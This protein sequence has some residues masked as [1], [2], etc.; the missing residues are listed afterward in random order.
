MNSAGGGAEKSKKRVT[1]FFW[2][3]PLQHQHFGRRR[4]LFG[5]TLKRTF[6]W[7]SEI[8]FQCIFSF[9]FL[10]KRKLFSVIYGRT[11]IYNFLTH[12]ILLNAAAEK[13]ETHTK[14]H[15]IFLRLFPLLI[16]I[17]T[18][19]YLFSIKNKFNGKR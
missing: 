2:M 4:Q 9:Y 13:N 15:K 16:N 18:L 5:V 3:D 19:S 7:F 14:V 10:F 17:N 6:Q 8:L 12:K 11:L 1:Y